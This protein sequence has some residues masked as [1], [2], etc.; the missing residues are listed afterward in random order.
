MWKNSNLGSFLIFPI[1]KELELLG[2]YLCVASKQILKFGFSGC[3]ASISQNNVNFP[4]FSLIHFH[5]SPSA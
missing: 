2:H 3:I 5:L 1:R 4:L